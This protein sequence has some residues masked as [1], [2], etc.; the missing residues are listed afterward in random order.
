MSNTEDLL[1][2]IKEITYK[3]KETSDRLESNWDKDR[4]DFAEFISRLGHLEE[5][6]KALRD[7]VQKVP[8]RTQE[9]V[10]EAVQPIADTLGEVKKETWWKKFTSRR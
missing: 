6:F 4:K 2:E 1:R 3:N 8:Q 10:S 7:Q 9:R 5:E